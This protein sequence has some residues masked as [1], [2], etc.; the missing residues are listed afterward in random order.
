VAFANIAMALGR[1]TMFA[2]TKIYQ[3]MPTPKQA[4]DLIVVRS[5]TSR[6]ASRLA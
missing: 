1:T 2:P 3:N 4:G 6:C 5:S